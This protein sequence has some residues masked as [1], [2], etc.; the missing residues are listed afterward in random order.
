MTPFHNKRVLHK[1]KIN[2]FDFFIQNQQ[3]L[4]DLM[5]FL[6]ITLISIRLES[7]E[8]NTTTI[9]ILFDLGRLLP[10]YQ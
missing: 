1:G 9:I 10:I 7:A 4:K 6:A 3:Y 8:K 5:Q 2:W